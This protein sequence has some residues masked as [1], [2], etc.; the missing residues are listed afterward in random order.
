MEDVFEANFFR[1]LTLVLD[2]VGDILDRA[3]AKIEE[4]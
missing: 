2:G 1:P 4:I 3:T